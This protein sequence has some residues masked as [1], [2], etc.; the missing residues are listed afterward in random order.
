[1]PAGDASLGVLQ[2]TEQQV[3]A[4]LQRWQTNLQTLV[5]ADADAAAAAASHSEA[6]VMITESHQACEQVM[7]KQKIQA[8][9]AEQ[10]VSTSYTECRS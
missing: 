8:Q 3:P 9:Y 10:Q 7:E 2:E 4:R 6:V 1:M 5:A